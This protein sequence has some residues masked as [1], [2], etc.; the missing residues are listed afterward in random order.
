MREREKKKRKRQELEKTMCERIGKRT[1][2][3]GGRERERKII[4][5]ERFEGDRKYSV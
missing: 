3:E 4:E 5:R 2:K 1:K